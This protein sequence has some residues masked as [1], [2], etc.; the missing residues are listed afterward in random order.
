[1]NPDPHIEDGMDR[2]HARGTRSSRAP[3]D[4]PP[5]LGE[6]SDRRRNAIARR[7]RAAF[8]DNDDLDR[9]ID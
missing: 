8:E 1:M 6:L 7:R 4:P 3:W 2:P 5:R 9:G